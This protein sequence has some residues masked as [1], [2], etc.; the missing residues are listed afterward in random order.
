MDQKAIKQA[1]HAGQGL[2]A[3][4]IASA[5][6]ALVFGICLLHATHPSASLRGKST[7]SMAGY[8]AAKA[9]TATIR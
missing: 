6:L 2:L 1:V 7:A 9:L 4:M 5:L 8:D 3:G